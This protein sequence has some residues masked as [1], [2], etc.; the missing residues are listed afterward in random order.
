MTDEARGMIR[1]PFLRLLAWLG[2]LASLVA[3]VGLGLT[4]AWFWHTFAGQGLYSTALGAIP[5]GTEARAIV[6]DIERVQAEVPNLPLRVQT[7]LTIKPDQARPGAQPADLF[8]GVSSAEAIDTYLDSSPYAVAR[9]IDQT[10][11]VVQVPG[12]SRP[13]PPESVTWRD[14]DRGPAPSVPIA[15]SSPVTVVAMNADGS[16]PVDLRLFLLVVVPDAQSYQGWAI[17]IAIG[18]IVLAWT[19]GYLALVRLAP[20]PREWSA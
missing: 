8:V 7:L 17:G 6:L 4:T 12:G 14:A 5:A 16:T 9:L 15:G 18:L 19:L 10:W 20:R 13:P 1:H 11:S 2:C 3:A